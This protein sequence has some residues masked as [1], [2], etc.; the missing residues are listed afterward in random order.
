[1]PAA[2]KLLD[3]FCDPNEDLASTI[4]QYLDYS[5]DHLALQ[6]A[7]SHFL[8]LLQ[9]VVPIHNLM[10]LFYSLIKNHS[11]PLSLRVPTNFVL[12]FE[13]AQQMLDFFG[14]KQHN[15]LLENIVTKF[16]VKYH[17]HPICL[18]LISCFR[19]NEFESPSKLQTQLQNNGSLCKMES[20]VGNYGI[21]AE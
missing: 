11:T 3:L 4:L 1:M 15:Y 5:K 20:V 18:Q 10:S 9:R 14:G 19:F 2:S 8:Q 13:M 16:V 21:R 6:L 17:Y 12:E 7:N